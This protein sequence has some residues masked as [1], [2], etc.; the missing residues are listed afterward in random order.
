MGDDQLYD[1]AMRTIVGLGGD[2]D[3]N[4]AIPGGLI[5]A[6]LGV[7]NIP[8]EKI[9][10]VLECDPALGTPRPNFVRPQFDGMEQIKKLISASPS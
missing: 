2:T 1:F 10:K 9:R 5:G 3:T 8:K 6:Y 7:S 4:C